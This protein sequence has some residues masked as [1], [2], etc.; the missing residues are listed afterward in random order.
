MWG[1]VIGFRVWAKTVYT[2]IYVYTY[3]H[4]LHTPGERESARARERERERELTRHASYEDRLV[5]HFESNAEKKKKEKN[6][7]H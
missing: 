2:R 4:T 5:R 6:L 3:I 7:A 1:L